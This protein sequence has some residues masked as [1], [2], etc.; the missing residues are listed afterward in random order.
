MALEAPSGYQEAMERGARLLA[1][2]PRTELE[3]RRRLGAAGFDTDDV[4]AAVARMIELN[5]IDDA[6]F[7]RQWIEERSKRKG[8]A[9]DALARELTARGIDRSVVEEM[10]AEA[11]L[12]EVGRATELADSWFRRVARH[13]LPVQAQRLQQMLA[14]KGYG[15][16]VAEEAVKAVLPPEGWD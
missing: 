10:V 7:A 15:W 4:D 3:L 9:G 11:D 12:D 2:R 16:E 1:V 5:L 13:P 14:R 8:L 6:A